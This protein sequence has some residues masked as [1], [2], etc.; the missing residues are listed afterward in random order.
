[1]TTPDEATTPAAAVARDAYWQVPRTDY[2]PSGRTPEQSTLDNPTQMDAAWTATVHAFNKLASEKAVQEAAEKAARELRDRIDRQAERRAQS[3]QEQAAA[4]VPHT[5][6]AA[7]RR[8]T[9]RLRRGLS[10]ST[11]EHG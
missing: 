10:P 8:A 1:M 4:P 3:R 7:T 9:F 5:A 11:A 2:V 6:P